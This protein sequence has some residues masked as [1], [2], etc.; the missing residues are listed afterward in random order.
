MLFGGNGSDVL[1]GDDGSDVLTGGN[2]IDTFQFEGP[3]EGVDT[4]TDFDNDVILGDIIGIDSTGFGINL[5]VIVQDISE[6][7]EA[8]SRGNVGALRLFTDDAGTTGV[9]DNNGIYEIGIDPVL[10]DAENSII[11]P[12]SVKLVL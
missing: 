7:I 11:D 9:Y 2:G 3:D 10:F 4:I 1:T 6:P 8:A 5:L 12:E